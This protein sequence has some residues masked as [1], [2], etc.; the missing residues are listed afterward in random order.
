MTL[1]EQDFETWLRAYGAAWEARD[2][3]AFSALFEQ[4]ALYYWTPFQDPKKGT[5]EIA[6]AF[7]DAVARQRDID[8]GARVLYVTAQLGAAHWSCAFTREGSGDR[9]H[10]D[11]PLAP[12]ETRNVEL[13]LAPGELPPG[14]YLARVDL[15]KEGAFWFEAMGI[16]P[17]MV[18]LEV[19]PGS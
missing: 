16:A 17:P 12:G 18:E 2:T 7:G 15:V 8:F 4:D 5:A 9:V 19:R 6:G 3:E 14:R 10:L 11:G 13:S 1:T